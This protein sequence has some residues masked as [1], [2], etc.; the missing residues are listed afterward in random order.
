MADLPVSFRFDAETLA[1]LDAI[2]EYHGVSRTAALEMLI[3]KEARAKKLK[4][5]EK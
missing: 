4:G 5:A 1:L 3:R 2:L